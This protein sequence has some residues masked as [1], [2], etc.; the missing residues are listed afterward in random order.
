[1]HGHQ[2]KEARVSDRDA[3][4][5]RA[6]TQ[7]GDAQRPGLGAGGGDAPPS[8]TASHNSN[9]EYFRPLRW[10]TDSLYLSYPG[11]LRPEV[12]SRLKSLKVLAQSQDPGKQAQAQYPLGDHIFE[13]K[14]RGAAL[15]PYILQDGTFRIQLA[16]PS[17]TLPMAYVKVSSG[18]LA[19]VSPTE[20]EQALSSLLAELGSLQSSA[21]VS[22]IDLFADF[23][24]AEDMD[25]WTRHA[26]VTR[27]ALVN[28]YAIDGKFSGW[29]IGAGGIV[30]ARLYDKRLEIETSGKYYLLDLWRKAGWDGSQPVW[31]LE[32][33]LKREA[34][35]QRGLSDLGTAM[36]NLNGLWSYATTEWLRLTLPYPEDK[37]RSRWPIHPLWG[38]LSA[39]DWETSGG[40]LTAQHTHAQ[41]PTDE[42]LFSMGFNALIAYMARE[43]MTDLYAGHQAFMTAMYAHLDQKAERQDK[44]FDPYVNDK[45]A[46]KAREFNSMLNN[47]D[48]EKERQEEEQERVA[49]AY[50][51]A[52]DGK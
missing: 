35:T 15:F 18:Y 5:S 4:H 32:F 30:S 25:S 29:T 7:G 41:L 19:H 36:N 42:K 52:S 20:A 31:R 50:R 33:Q 1:M 22:R 9:P 24:T 21:N 51:K 6:G 23:A 14:D 10:G 11:E 2:D 44:P 45:L 48:Q 3:P 17:K 40:P 26:W 28:A 47:P 27:A 37:T 13:V 34:L 38:C 46:L 43:R 16:R 12:E 49:K 8:N 39:I